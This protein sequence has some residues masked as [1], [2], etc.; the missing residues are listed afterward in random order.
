M[1]SQHSG[2]GRDRFGSFAYYGGQNF[3][4]KSNYKMDNYYKDKVDLLTQEKKDWLQLQ[5]ELKKENR[6][7]KEQIDEF[8]KKIKDLE[9]V[10]KRLGAFEDDGVDFDENSPEPLRQEKA[11]KDDF[12]QDINKSVNFTIDQRGIHKK[13]NL[14][15]NQTIIQETIHLD[16]RD[17]LIYQTQMEQAKIQQSNDDENIKPS[18]MRVDRKLT[19]MTTENT[20]SNLRN[21]NENEMSKYNNVNATSSSIPSIPQTQNMEIK[22]MKNRYQTA[23][24]Q[25]GRDEEDYGVAALASNFNRN[26]PD[27]YDSL[28]SKGAFMNKSGSKYNRTIEADKSYDLGADESRP[29][30][31]N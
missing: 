23:F 24:G 15:E 1:K 27:Q 20:P 4:D 16:D 2:Y 17:Q 12:N 11:Q 31:E 10:I 3:N 8:K 19:T 6:D 13:G 29:N 7:L 30:I 28:R 21:I 9:A 18:P 26:M 22:A 25:R 5:K 14:D